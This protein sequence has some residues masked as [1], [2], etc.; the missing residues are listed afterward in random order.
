MNERIVKN[1]QKFMERI[2]EERA[3]ILQY[4]CL[5]EILWTEESGQCDPWGHK[6]QR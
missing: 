1:K 4:S 3:A 2:G 6:E 5:E